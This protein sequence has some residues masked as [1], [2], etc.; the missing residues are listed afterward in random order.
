MRAVQARAIPIVG[1]TAR[2]RRLSSSKP[3]PGWSRPRASAVGVV[4]SLAN[5]A[6][7]RGEAVWYHRR[8]V[9]PGP[10]NDSRAR[11]AGGRAGGLPALVR[12]LLGASLQWLSVRLLGVRRGGRHWV[13]RHSAG[14]RQ[15][16][17]LRQEVAGAR[18]G[19]LARMRGSQPNVDHDHGV[20][21][22]ATAR[23]PD[24]G[25][26]PWSG[27]SDVRAGEFVQFR[28]ALGGHRGAMRESY[29]ELGGRRRGSSAQRDAT[30]PRGGLGSVGKRARRRGCK[31]YR[32]V[33]GRRDHAHRRREG[34]DWRT[35]PERLRRLHR[36]LQ[37]G[38]SCGASDGGDVPRPGQG[39][40]FRTEG[41]QSGR[42]E[43]VP[44]KVDRH[45]VDLRQERDTSRT[46]FGRERVRAPVKAS[47][48]GRAA[49][50]H[51]SFHRAR[52][53][54]EHHGQVPDV[55]SHH[56]QRHA[57]PAPA[58]LP[59]RRLP[60]HNADRG[61]RVRRAGKAALASP[62]RGRSRR[63]YGER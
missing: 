21:L 62:E 26:P 40:R 60:V 22:G 10:G 56:R 53:A 46:H 37:F 20:L 30:A 31:G 45:L 1:W 44:R 41:D 5:R 43:S 7:R 36:R 50:Q 9:L 63:D 39:N 52:G 34:L 4:H 19:H 17:R 58:A 11:S 6:G 33:L 32:G 3:L 27:R 42:G 15:L 8:R 51:G 13:H 59:G 48:P 38:S 16:L 28:I 25:K 24:A 2:A 18:E 57:K 61:R 29:W 54:R 55:G 23:P 47:Q 49:Q 14:E 12:K 35:A